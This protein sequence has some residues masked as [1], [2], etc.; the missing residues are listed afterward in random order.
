MF[1]KHLLLTNLGISM[2]LSV[3]GDCL[4][5]HYEII[6]S[7]ERSFDKK[8][9]FHMGTSGLTV[10]FVCH[11]WY[12]YLD[13]FLPGRAIRTVFKKVVVDQL[14]GSPA[15]ISTFFITLALLERS[16]ADEFLAELK[17][18]SWRLYLAEWVIWPPAQVINFY[19]LPTRYRVLYDNTISLGYDVYFSHVKHEI[20]VPSSNSKNLDSNDVILEK[21]IM[22][23][24]DDDL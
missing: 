2:S 22:S 4:Q 8:R 1:R 11:H 7:G 13:R 12:K 14:I 15:A 21:E 17:S 24:D 6:K 16:S 5:Q 18:K 19:I 9:S 10:G 20:P 23:S 3:T